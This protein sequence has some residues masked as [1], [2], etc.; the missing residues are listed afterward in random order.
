MTAIPRAFG[1]ACMFALLCWPALTSPANLD[2]HY[3]EQCRQKRLY[4]ALNHCERM[5]AR[6]VYV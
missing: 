3:A 2:R 4:V 6:G 5:R 1:L